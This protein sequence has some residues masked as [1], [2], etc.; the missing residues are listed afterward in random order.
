MLTRK[1]EHQEST[2]KA[3]SSSK[4]T[5]KSNTSCCQ[6]NEP[7][8]QNQ[9]KSWGIAQPTPQSRSAKT[10]ITIHYNVG[11]NNALFIRGKGAN[12]SW[13]RGVQLRNVAADRWVWDCDAPFTVAEFKI[14]VNDNIYEEGANHTLK[15]G[16][17]LEYTPRFPVYV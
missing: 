4:I 14:L 6:P 3:K 7:C 9:E 2:G 13:E 1:D 15:C 11:F 8:Q 12:L 16:A 10:R 5:P 17:Q